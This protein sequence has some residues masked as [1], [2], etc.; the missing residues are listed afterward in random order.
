MKSIFSALKHSL[1]I[2][3]KYPSMELYIMCIDEM[4][5]I[6]YHKNFV[7]ETFYIKCTK[8]ILHTLTI[9]KVMQLLL[10]NIIDSIEIY[11]SIGIRYVNRTIYNYKNKFAQTIQIAWRKHR[12]RTARIRNDLVLHG[13]AEWWYHPSKITFE[14][15]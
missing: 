11:G 4:Y 13:L 12:L 3:K 2:I 1:E 7:D 9:N 15:N 6:S 5:T 10:E 14:I 8:F